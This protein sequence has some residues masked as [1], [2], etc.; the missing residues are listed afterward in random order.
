MLGLIGAMI[1]F[2]PTLTALVAVTVPVIG[3][4]VGV[5]EP[6]VQTL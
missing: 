5:Y 2:S 3:F 4:L 1:Y 6:G